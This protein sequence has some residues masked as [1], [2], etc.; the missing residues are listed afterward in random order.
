MCVLGIKP[1]S[2]EKVASVLNFWDISAPS[3][4]LSAFL[5]VFIPI[6]R[7]PILSGFLFLSPPFFWNIQLPQH[8]LLRR[9]LFSSVKGLGIH[10]SLF[11][12]SRFWLLILPPTFAPHCL[13]HYSII[14]NFTIRSA[15]FPALFFL[16]KVVLLLCVPCIF[17]WTLE[18]S[19]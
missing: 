14:G 16:L 5:M 7:F 3:Y 9:L 2:P 18:P 11:L 17:Q 6:R 13:G 1:G 15:N 8:C 12:E 10:E 4:I 19:C